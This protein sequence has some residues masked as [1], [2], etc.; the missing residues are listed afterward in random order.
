[1]GGVTCPR[2]GFAE[3]SGPVCP[4]CGTVFAKLRGPR[5]RPVAPPEPAP[6]PPRT[7]RVF[8][9]ALA[10]AGLALALGVAARV[11]VPRPAPE[12][13]PAPPAGEPA[14]PPLDAAP[15]AAQPP[16]AAPPSLAAAPQPP[17]APAT[18]TPGGFTEEDEAKLRA[19]EDVVRGANAG[20]AFHA[21]E[22]EGLLARYPGDPYVVR[23]AAGT[24]ISVGF[25]EGRARRFAE[26]GARFRRAAEL[27]P[28]ELAPRLSLANLLLEAGD[29]PAAEA[30]ARDALALDARNVEA[31]QALAFALYRQDRSAEALEALRA[32][33][34]IRETSEARELLAR[35]EKGVRDERGMREQ[36]IAHFHVRYD[37]EA[38]EDVGR[39]ILRALER[40]YATL[41][42]TLDHQPTTTIPVVLFT[43][44]QYYDASGAPA[45]AGGS[46]DGIDGR[47]R[48]P[49]GGLTASLTPGIDDTL[50]HELTHAFVAD[51][52]RGIAPR[53]LHEGLAQ[54]MEGK[55]TSTLPR[56][57]LAAMA[58]GRLGGVHG[59]YLQA[60]AFVEYLVSQ[61]GQGGINGLLEAMG[62]T[63]KL[64]D[65]SRRAYG[66][67]WAEL[68]Q[69]WQARMRQQHGS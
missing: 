60:L 62:E 49:I 30:A 23:L 15:P 13:A 52:T 57:A 69:D 20:T 58:D 68:R 34:A 46:Y 66:R 22:A 40:H 17:P 53:E 16:A 35:I 6:E 41:V 14:E 1:M 38:H 27:L 3:A 43:R 37:G 7:G 47:I 19:L 25:G 44:D 28:L 29:W 4:G 54:Y 48:I 10:A 61:R 45:W 42:T 39:E 50:I 11:F 65:G 21:I 9:L 63:G 12:A 55:R 36:R 5:P 2:C 59:F 31:L 51:A 67:S 26:A 64:D 18:P 33:L 32:A 8:S 56:E 24:L